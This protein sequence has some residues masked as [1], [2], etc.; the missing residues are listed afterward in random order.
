MTFNKDSDKWEKLTRVDKLGELLVRLNVLKLSQLTDLMEEQRKDDSLRIGEIAVKKGLITKDD[1]LKYL[2][3]QLNEGKVVDES[4]KELGLMTNDEKWERL[5]QMERLGEILL[6]K[7]V[8]K[9]SQL[10]E[11]IEIQA[12]Y[13]DKHLGELLIEKGIISEKDLEEALDWQDNQNQVLAETIKE[14]KN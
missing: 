12:Q 2:E 1:L 6:K 9:L 3:I 10:T 5:L 8:L 14:I 4:L 11:A 13:P 7:N